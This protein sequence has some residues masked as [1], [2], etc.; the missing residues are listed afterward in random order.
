MINTGQGLIFLAFLF[1]GIINGLIY[2]I[3]RVFKTI[4]A[5]FIYNIIIDILLTAVTGAGLLFW[6]F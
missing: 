5:N 2:E 6:A 3:L 1:G 4:S